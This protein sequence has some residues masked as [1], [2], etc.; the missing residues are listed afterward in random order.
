MTRIQVS[1]RRGFT[2]R[3]F[4]ADLQIRVGGSSIYSSTAAW[5]RLQM[6]T[7]GKRVLILIHGYNNDFY[8]ARAAYTDVLDNLVRECGWALPYDTILEVYWPGRTFLGFWAAVGAANGAGRRLRDLL[9]RLWP[10]S[11]DI[12]THSLGARVA[13]EALKTGV[14][15]GTVRNL[16]LTAPAVDDESLGAKE[17]Q[18]YQSTLCCQRVLVCYSQNDPVLGK[19]YRRL[20]SLPWNLLSGGDAALGWSG[21][22]DIFSCSASVETLNDSDGVLTHGGWK[23]S[24]ALLREWRLLV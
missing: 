7:D 3:M 14:T 21:P 16:I 23:S 9:V 10:A 8:A 1:F 12:E 4:P 15:P 13:L 11:V 6:A 20:G 17:D 2:G 18:Y 22:S 19:W 24:S 5:S